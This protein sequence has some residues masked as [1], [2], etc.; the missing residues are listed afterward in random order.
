M[1]PIMSF[2]GYQVI[3]N[4]KKSNDLLNNFYEQL[5]YIVSDP[6]QQKTAEV[7]SVQESPKPV[8]GNR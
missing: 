5:G 7:N 3:E 8:S 2:E 1:E 6:H 4:T